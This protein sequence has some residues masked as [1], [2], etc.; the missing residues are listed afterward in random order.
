MKFAKSEVVNLED[1]AYC[2]LDTSSSPAK[3]NELPSIISLFCGAGGLD[4]GFKTAGFEISVAID[5]SDAA[6]KTHKKNFPD[7][8][9]IAA[10]LLDL[11][12]DGVFEI[13]SSQI[14]F[15]K[16]IAI[17]GGPPCQGFSR[18]NV[19]A[20]HDDPRNSLPALYLE[21]VKKLQERY[22][23]E[24]ITIENVLGIRD[25]KHKAIYE[26]LLAEIKNLGFKVRV[27]EL[28]SLDYGVPQTRKR[29]FILGNKARLYCFSCKKKPYNIIKTVRQAI[30]GL[31][32]P[33]FFHKD[34]NE[35]QIGFHPNHWTMKPKSARFSNPELFL[36]KHSRSFRKLKW[37]EPSP[38]IAFGNREI[39]VHPEG[40]RRLSIYEAMLLQ[41]FPNSFI[42]KGNLSE[43]VEQV[44][45]AVPPPMAE[46]IA[47]GFKNTLELGEQN[48]KE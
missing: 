1:K 3:I 18:A 40:R 46:S 15:G 44:S 20:K 9:S 30:D 22:S 39:Y 38:T 28:C 7:T 19:R 33:V 47:N 16:K 31:P 10:D 2:H 36:E 11:K 12:A 17:I 26:S 6:I 27:E 5:L 4:L 29:V 35:C 14:P 48:A 34:L 45:N 8:Y 25:K 21:V 24:F 23:V 42:L 41:G 43:Q 37:D 32:E 13:V